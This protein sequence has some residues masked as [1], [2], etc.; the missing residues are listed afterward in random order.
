MN[1]ITSKTG[2]GILLGLLLVLLFEF[3]SPLLFNIV[4]SLGQYVDFDS[5]LVKIVFALTIVLSFFLALYNKI[6]YKYKCNAS[7]IHFYMIVAFTVIALYRVELIPHEW[8]FINYYK[9]LLYV[10]FLVLYPICLLIYYICNK[11]LDKEDEELVGT[12]EGFEG[13]LL[14][15]SQDLFRFKEDAMSLIKRID[16]KDINNQALIIG[17]RGSWGS[18]KTSYLY[19]LKELIESQ[20]KEKRKFCLKHNYR[21]VEFSPWLSIGVEQMIKDFFNSLHKVIKEKPIQLKL[22]R[23]ARKVVQADISW[24]SR[25]LGLFSGVTTKQIFD[26]FKMVLKNQPVRYIVLIDDLDRLDTEE[27][28]RTIQL[29]RNI[30]DFP[31]VIFVVAYDENYVLERIKYRV[32]Q[33]MKDSQ[34]YLQK[35]FTLPHYLPVKKPEILFEEN[36]KRISSILGVIRDEDQ[37]QIKEFLRD[38]EREFSL[39][40]SVLL[41]NNTVHSLARMKSTNGY[42]VCLYDALLLN[43]LQLVNNKVYEG[44]YKSFIRDEYDKDTLLLV[45]CEYIKL[46]N[47]KTSAEKVFSKNK[48]GKQSDDKYLKELLKKVCMIVNED[49][50]EEDYFIHKPSKNKALTF[51][52]RLE[53]HANEH[54]VDECSHILQLMFGKLKDQEG[55]NRYVQKKERIE[56]NYR[57]KNK[58]VF[59]AYFENVLPGDI[60]SQDDFDQYLLDVTKFEEQLPKWVQTLNRSL[61]RRLLLS[62]QFRGREQGMGLLKASLSVIP[63]H[64]HCHENSGEENMVVLVG[65]GYYLKSFNSRKNIDYR[66]FYE[67]LVISFLT[68]KKDLA[69]KAQRFYILCDF[70]GWNKNEYYYFIRSYSKRKGRDDKELLKELYKPYIEDYLKNMTSY[71]DF[72]KIYLFC[73]ENMYGEYREELASL[74]KEHMQR[75]IKSFM[76]NYPVSYLEDEDL[77]QILFEDRNKKNWRPNMIEYLDSFSEKEKKE[78]IFKRYYNELTNINTDN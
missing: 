53:K 37:Y 5:V 33:D 27:I 26:D 57:I 59:E 50:K 17:L 61:L 73:L 62:V 43:L 66:I 31:N 7:S 69:C 42:T 47:G 49:Y 18:G 74:F 78:P 40:E 11:I 10:D 34:F 77:F 51:R 32:G 25:I 71:K 72:N 22:Q 15:S 76:E 8:K 52:E 56:D 63:D 48:H 12:T 21:V 9:G 19:I 30:A 14:Y 24:L 67:D 3:F 65:F 28:M 4:T 55:E 2:Y 1:K 64:S 68:Y 38:V 46:H 23:Y 60:I 45:D 20:A 54:R 44:L 39:R 36:S 70:V 41:A 16:D 58:E 29:I 75:Y 6:Q 35:I 13:P